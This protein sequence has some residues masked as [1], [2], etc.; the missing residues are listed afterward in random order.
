MYSVYKHR[1]LKQ[2]TEE[3]FRQGQVNMAKN[4]ITAKV[5]AERKKDCLSVA[6]VAIVAGLEHFT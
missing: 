5:M 4:M 1:L 3:E 2:I 6:V